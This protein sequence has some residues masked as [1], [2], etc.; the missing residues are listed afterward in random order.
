M[1]VAPDIS[2]QTAENITTGECMF[3]WFMAMFF[4][5]WCFRAHVYAVGEQHAQSCDER[6][7]IN[8]CL[9]AIIDGVRIG[10]YIIHIWEH[11]HYQCDNVIRITDVLMFVLL[12]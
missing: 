12:E 10:R 6:I 11:L 2:I 4:D 3:V 8:G 1:N 5:V 9:S 7:M